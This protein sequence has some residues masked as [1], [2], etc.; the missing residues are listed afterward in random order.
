MKRSLEILEDEPVSVASLLRHFHQFIMKSLWLF[1]ERKVSAVLEPDQPLGR[2]IEFSV[3]AEASETTQGRLTAL[4]SI[5]NS[6]E[7]SLGRL[8]AAYG[9]FS[10]A[11]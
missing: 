5:D 1:E 7:A 2:G 6:R 10:R 11:A 4:F 9:E 8:M 3:I